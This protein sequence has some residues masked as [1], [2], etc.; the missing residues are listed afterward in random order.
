MEKNV[1]G[2]KKIVL[3]IQHTISNLNFSIFDFKKC[4][5]KFGFWKIFNS[6]LDIKNL[7]S[8][9][10]FKMYKNRKI[11]NRIEEQSIQIKKN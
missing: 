3:E 6:N 8:K 11:K 4:G 9:L 2:L 10:D 7:H 1:S 5:Y